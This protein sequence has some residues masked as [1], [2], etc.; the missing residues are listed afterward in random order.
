MGINNCSVKHVEDQLDH[1]QFK[2]ENGKQIVD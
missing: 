2:L 1:Y